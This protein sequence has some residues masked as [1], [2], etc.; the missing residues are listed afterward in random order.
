MKE[1]KIISKRFWSKDTHFEASLNQFSKMGWELKA[2]THLNG[3]IVKA[4]LEREK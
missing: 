2:I 1:Y 3:N 4:I